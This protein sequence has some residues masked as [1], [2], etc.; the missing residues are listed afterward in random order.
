MLKCCILNNGRH[1]M[2]IE[3]QDKFANPA[4][5]DKRISIYYDFQHETCKWL[6]GH[7]IYVHQS[8]LNKHILEQPSTILIR[9]L[10]TTGIQA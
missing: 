9:S 4:L 8:Q 2:I 1:T 3:P 5:Q 10:E 7:L 6:T